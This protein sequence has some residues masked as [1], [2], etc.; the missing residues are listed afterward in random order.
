M[1]YLKII[2]TY[3]LI[4]LISKFYIKA[5]DIKNKE[6]KVCYAHNLLYCIL[7]D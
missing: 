3:N 6:I 2:R 1:K 7:N 4:W 5:D